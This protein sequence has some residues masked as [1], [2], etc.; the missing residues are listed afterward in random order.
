MAGHQFCAGTEDTKEKIYEYMLSHRDVV[1]KELS[2][3]LS[4]PIGALSYSIQYLVARGHLVKRIQRHATT[5]FA[6]YNLG[7]IEFRKRVRVPKVKLP[8]SEAPTKELSEEAKSVATVYRL[9]DRP[10]AAAPKSRKRTKVY[11]G[12]TMG[13]FDAL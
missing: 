9:L 2:A 6:V 13:L 4:I 5:R 3:D 1:L 8:K 10:R 12:S 11:I 7:K